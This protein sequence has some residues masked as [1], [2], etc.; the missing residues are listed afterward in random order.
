MKYFDK[1]K[2][3]V[4]FA[5]IFLCTFAGTVLAWSIGYAW[6]SGMMWGAAVGCGFYAMSMTDRSPPKE[7]RRA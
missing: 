4:A 7:T 5:Q 2:G 6:Q 3:M 1:H